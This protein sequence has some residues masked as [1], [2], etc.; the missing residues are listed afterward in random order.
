[1]ALIILATLFM[2]IGAALGLR[3]KAFVLIPANCL[4][5]VC[6]LLTTLVCGWSPPFL[7]LAITTTIVAVLIGYSFGVASWL[8]KQDDRAPRAAKFWLPPHRLS[9]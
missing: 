1:M 4:A 3:F 8:A 6:V 5:F 7:V 9:D 2:V